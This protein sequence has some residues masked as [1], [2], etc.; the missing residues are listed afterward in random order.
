MF[1]TFRIWFYCDVNWVI[2]YWD[3]TNHG[4]DRCYFFL[5]RISH[6]FSIVNSKYEHVCYIY[7]IEVRHWF[8]DVLTVSLINKRRHNYGFKRYLLEQPISPNVS[9]DTL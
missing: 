5:F 4:K 7:V 9:F 1:V 3:S 2:T 8:Y 6:R